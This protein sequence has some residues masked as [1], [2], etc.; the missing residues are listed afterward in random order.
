[1]T[2]VTGLAMVIVVFLTMSSAQPALARESGSLL[3]SF[4]LFL[5]L[6]FVSG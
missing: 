5:G 1:M 3:K 2:I 4:F 6:P